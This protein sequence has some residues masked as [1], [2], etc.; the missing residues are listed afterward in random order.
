MGGRSVKRRGER[1]RASELALLRADTS[2]GPYSQT[3]LDIS[4]EAA[5]GMLAKATSRS[6]GNMGP[7]GSQGAWEGPGA[8]HLQA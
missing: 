5:S 1:V 7:E 2:M 8:P 6:P 4:A 3:C